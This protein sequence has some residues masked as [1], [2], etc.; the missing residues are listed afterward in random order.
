[1]PLTDI[2]QTLHHQSYPAI[3]VKERANAA[4][5][6]TVVVSG[7]AGG[8][9]YGI[10]KSFV[11]AGAANVVI[12]ARRQEAL[13][14]AVPQLQAVVLAAGGGTA[15]WQYLVDITDADGLIDAFKGIRQRLN[16]GQGGDKDADILVANAAVLNQGEATLDFDLNAYRS[17][18]DTNVIG[19]LNL[20]HAFLAPEMPS[21]PFTSFVGDEKDAAPRRDPGHEKIVIDVSTAAF[22]WDLPGQ[23]PY[24]ASKLA[25][26]RI[27]RTLHTEVAG[28]PGSAVRIHSFNPGSVAT[29]GTSKILK[30]KMDVIP[31][32]DISLPSDFAVWLTSPAADFTAGRFLSANWDVD[33][34][35]AQK[36]KF[37]EDPGYCA[38]NIKA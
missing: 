36:S 16:G 19:N 28:L 37:L 18:F 27:L 10:S 7:G 32:E 38:I 1:M 15:I 14:E 29:P 5:G 4:A 35:V 30:G 20:V 13:D 8:I 17:A 11:Q 22:A 24:A 33:E 26:T 9:G 23:A 21:I 3:S 2:T 12:L 25:F 6:K 31:W 34:L